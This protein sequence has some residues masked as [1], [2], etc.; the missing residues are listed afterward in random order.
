MNSAEP[1]TDALARPP[2]ERPSA[3][4]SHTFGPTGMSNTL[5]QWLRSGAALAL[6]PWIILAILVVLYGAR[7]AGVYTIN[8]LNIFTGETLTLILIS[9]C[10]TLVIVSGGIDLSSGGLLSLVT[11]IAALHFGDGGAQMWWVMAALIIGSTAA[12]AVNGFL[13]GVTGMQPFI[14]TLATSSVFGGA[15]LWVLPTNGGTV[16]ANWSNFGNGVWLGIGTPVWLLL[17]LALFWLIFKRTRLWFEIRSVGSSQEAAFLSGVPVTRTIVTTY[18]LAG[19]FACLAAL[20]YITQSES[21][22]PTVGP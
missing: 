7:Q 3:R 20:Y 14:V 4:G 12:G 10:Q 18:A 11:A 9:F 19:L 17:L 21:G 16:P 2:G 5:A 15:A 13:I 6:T 1:R 8:E 22:N